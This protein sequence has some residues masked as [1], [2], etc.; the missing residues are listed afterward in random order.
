MLKLLLRRLRSLLSSLPKVVQ[1]SYLSN[2][3]LRRKIPKFQRRPT[4]PIFH[5][6]QQRRFTTD[7]TK[8]IIQRLVLTHHL[9]HRKPTVRAAHS[10]H[11]RPTRINNTVHLNSDVTLTRKCVRT[12]QRVI[13]TSS[14]R[15][16]PRR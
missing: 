5:K 9:L 2:S 14:S 13:N 7:S 15:V 16:L 11:S 8:R 12:E 4:F 1:I 3:F 10:G 6:V